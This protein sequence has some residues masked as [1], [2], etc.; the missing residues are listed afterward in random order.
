MLYSIPIILGL[1]AFVVVASLSISA[2][3]RDRFSRSRPSPPPSPLPGPHGKDEGKKDRIESLPRSKAELRLLPAC[4][5]AFHA[6]CVAAWLRTTPT[7]PLSPAIVAPSHPSIAALLAAEQ[8]LPTPEPAAARS[9]DR[10]R[11]FRVEMGNVSTRGGS[12]AT[13]TG[14]GLKEGRT[15]DR[16]KAFHWKKQDVKGQT[17]RERYN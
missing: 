5:H 17:T 15:A 10:S 3:L 1:F 7:I 8:P 13:S 9:R 11:R 14:S 2:C 16:A 6:A 4:R 12:P